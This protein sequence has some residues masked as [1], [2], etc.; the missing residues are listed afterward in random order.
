MLALLTAEIPTDLREIEEELFRV[1]GE[2]EIRELYFSRLASARAA[3]ERIDEE[4]GEQT[5]ID[6]LRHNCRMTQQ[7]AADRVRV[8]DKLDAMPVSEDAFY[9]GAIGFQHLVVMARTAAW[10]STASSTP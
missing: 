4:G 10:S 9:N 1:R 3:H 6:W 2:I 5:N 8:G 7:A